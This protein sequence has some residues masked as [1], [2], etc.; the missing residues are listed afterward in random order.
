MIKWFRFKNFQSYLDD[1]EVDLTVNQKVASSYF[2]HE[3]NDKSK[4]AKVLGVFGGNGAGKSN[5]IKPLSFIS[6]FIPNS[7]Y[8][9]EK[10]EKIPYHPHFLASDHLR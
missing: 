2:D 1:C 5:L 8:E 7:F 3:L 6:W 10:N 4:V 9:M